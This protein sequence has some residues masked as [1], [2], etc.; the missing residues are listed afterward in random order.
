VFGRL[1]RVGQQHKEA[2][3]ARGA[4]PNARQLHFGLVS[5]HVCI[6]DDISTAHRMNENKEHS[7]R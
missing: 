4:A 6:E 1:G 5:A 2:Q 3:R 7:Q